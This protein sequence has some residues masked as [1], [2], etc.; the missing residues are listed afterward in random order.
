MSKSKSILG[1]LVLLL[2]VVFIYSC[3]KD[4]TKSDQNSHFTTESRN[5]L[6]AASTVINGML[7]FNTYADFEGYIE[8]LEGLENDTNQVIAAYTQLGVD[9]TQ[10]FLPNLTDYPVA[11]RIEQQI[12]GFTSARKAEE[13]V[14][15]NALNSGND[16]I[17]TIISD[18]FLKSALNTDYAVHIG[19]RI[20][21]FFNN[22]GVVI[23]LNND[24][25]LY[26]SIKTMQ[27]IDINPAPNIYVTNRVTEKWGELYHLDTNGHPLSE[28]V[29]TNPEFVVL[30]DTSACDHLKFLTVVTLDNGVVRLTVN[31]IFSQYKWTFVDGSVLYGKTVTKKITTS[32]MVRI[33]ILKEDGTPLCKFS[34]WYDYCGEKKEKL[35]IYKN[36]NA[37][38][39]GKWVRIDAL[40]WVKAGEIGCSSKLYSKNFLGIVFPLNYLHSTTGV[41][42]DIIGNIKRET[43]DTLVQ[44]CDVVT[45]PLTT[46]CLQKNQ[47]NGSV[48][49]K[50]PQQGNIFR[51]AG[52]LSSGHKARLKTGGTF[53][54]FGVDVP[55]L[56]LD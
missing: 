17:F 20:F 1:T 52:K 48:T 22:G 11:L 7:H 29:F 28:K 16:T 12:T 46:E 40:I 34:F 41:C 31:Y 45:I 32:G 26:D 3:A 38:G 10:E 50:L 18:P 14:I 19:T 27:F 33:T 21:R 49:L 35:N 15:N 25:N 37:G 8:N 24:W 6:S 54:G 13:T 55:R 44:Q 51:E 23:V 39:S 42:V 9:L 47:S 53:F 4:D 5:S 43:S 2:A 56:V 30:N 36:P